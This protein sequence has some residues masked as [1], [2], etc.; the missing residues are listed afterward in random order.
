MSGYHSITCTD[1]VCDPGC[2]ATSGEWPEFPGQVD[3]LELLGQAPEDLAAGRVGPGVLDQVVTAATRYGHVA[4]CGCGWK[5][6]HETKIAGL[7]AGRRHVRA[8]HSQA[9]GPGR[10]A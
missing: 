8:A 6:V 9:R 1:T 5:A 7:V 4:R 10:V 3:L 2:R